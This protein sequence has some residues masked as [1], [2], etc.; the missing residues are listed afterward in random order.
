MCLEAD[1][2]REQPLPPTTER[3]AAKRSERSNWRAGS[4][5]QYPQISLV[6][7]ARDQR[8]RVVLDGPET[9]SVD[10]IHSVCTKRRQ[11]FVGA[12]PRADG[13]GHSYLPCAA[14]RCRT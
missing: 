14:T 10:F 13:E 5:Q 2:W 7:S 8:T 4:F 1:G 9:D 12:E 11:D 3:E 6:I